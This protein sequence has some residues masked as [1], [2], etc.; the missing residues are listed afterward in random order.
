MEEPIEFKT[1]SQQKE[2]KESINKEVQA[3]IKN[4]T[5]DII[6]KPAD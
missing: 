5:L 2:W 4:K 6:D 1:A 3:I